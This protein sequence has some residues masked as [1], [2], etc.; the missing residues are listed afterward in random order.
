[1]SDK[2]TRDNEATKNRPQEKQP[3]QVLH[4]RKNIPFCPLRMAIGG[5]AAAAAIGYLVLYTKKKPEAS[6][7]DVAKVTTGVGATPDST[8]SR[9]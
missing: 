7:M 2:G 3:S 5:A 6:A 4:Q 1:M 8:H 9:K